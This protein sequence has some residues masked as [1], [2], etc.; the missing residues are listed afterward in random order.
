MSTLKDLPRVTD[1][2][3]PY[4]NFKYVEK[5]ILMRA[6]ERGT[7]VH[8]LCASIAKGDWVPDS[9]I[10]PALAGYV[11]SFKLWHKD[12]I[13]GYHVIEKR[14]SNPSLGYTGQVD[15]VVKLKKSGNFLVDLKTSASP[16]KTYPVQMAAYMNL[17]AHCRDNG[18]KVQGAI[19]V[20]L[21]K[22]G[23]YPKVHQMDDWKEELEV[24]LHALEC[25]KFFNKRKSD[26]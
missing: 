11:R 9:L 24:F 16:Q 15:F 18:L 1:I 5:T 23:E 2:L 25:W 14:Y 12:I 26:E 3:K 20:Y 8:G 22:E 10:D 13:E 7:A 6:A 17:I 4:S 21:D 19:I